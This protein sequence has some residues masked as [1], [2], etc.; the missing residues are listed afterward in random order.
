MFGIGSKVFI[1]AAEFEEV[2]DGVAVT[3]GGE[4]RGEG[5]V[6]LSEAAFGELVGGVDAGELV[7]HGHAEEV[8]SVELEAA[9]RLGV[10]EECSGGVVEYER[11]LED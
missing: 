1:A 11:R 10:T 9:T 2:E 5:P 3:L 4:A 8:G 7:L 6:H